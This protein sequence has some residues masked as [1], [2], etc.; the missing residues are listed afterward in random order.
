MTVK[1]RERD[2]LEYLGVD[3]ICVDWIQLAQDS[4]HVSGCCDHG[5]EL[6]RYIK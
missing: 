1:L 4:N 5:N 6:S 2:H 3:G